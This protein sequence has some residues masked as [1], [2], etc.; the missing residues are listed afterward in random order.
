MNEYLTQK[1]WKMRKNIV[2]SPGT[3]VVSL[4][5][6]RKGVYQLL[7]TSCGCNRACSF[8]NYGFDY[9]LTFEKVMPELQK[10]SFPD[11][12]DVLQ[13]ESNGSFLSERE[14][15]LDLFIEVLKY[16]STKNIPEIEIETHYET[17]TEEKLKM[18]RSI[19]G[20][21]QEIY[22]EVGFESSSEDVRAIY[23]KD[24]HTTSFL[25]T[26]DMCDKY[27]IGVL[28]NL[29]LGCPF[30]SREEQIL[31]VLNSM[32]FVFSN[33]PKKTMCVIFPINIKE[34]TM[35]KHWQE[36]GVY[37]QISSWELVE[38]LYRIPDEYL[39]RITVAWF[40]TRENTFTKG[41]SQFP[42]TCE[43]CHDRLI[44]FYTDF[45]N[46]LSKEYRKRITEKIWAS[47]C[48][49]DHK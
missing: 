12:I 2:T 22:F 36:V 10:I 4:N 27:N 3:P 24:I 44:N 35:I 1:I 8:C 39:E 34:N 20:G 32:D 6:T 49:C 25:E 45:C 47:R 37:D 30:L 13:L 18:I 19:F 40:G 38:L 26:I 7:F 23:N 43:K 33:T 14:I 41:I 46:H 42:K 15:P 31:D 5:K 29:L 11:D 28:I 9:N 17:I 21:K 16:V 48:D